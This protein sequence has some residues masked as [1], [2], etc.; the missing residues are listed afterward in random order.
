MGTTAAQKKLSAEHEVNLTPLI[1]V[2]LVLVVMLLLATPLAFESSIKVSTSPE[3][4][5]A[6]ETPDQNELIE[7][8]VFADDRVRINRTMVARA[9]MEN[10]LR[11]MLE[12]SVRRQVTLS[13]EKGV[14]HGARR[15]ET[16][17]FPWRWFGILRIQGHESVVMMLRLDEE[18][19]SFDFA[20]KVC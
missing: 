15:A 12:A 18:A 8:R 6:A 5:Q 1:D 17:G 9:D 13:A 2:A 20:K 7:I 10:V 3:T 19:G 4:A 11:P 16:Q 14:T